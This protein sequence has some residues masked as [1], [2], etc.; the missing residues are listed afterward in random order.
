MIELTTFVNIKSFVT[1]Y[2][3]NQ[4]PSKIIQETYTSRDA[5]RGREKAREISSPFFPSSDL[6]IIPPLGKLTRD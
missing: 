4:S 1:E 2:Y 5:T 3:I 6:P